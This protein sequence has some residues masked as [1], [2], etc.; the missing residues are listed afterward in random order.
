MRVAAP[1]FSSR[2]H[3]PAFGA[4]RSALPFISS[5]TSCRKLS[6]E[7]NGYQIVFCRGTDVPT[8]LAAGLVDVGLM[9]YDVSVEWC[10]RMHARLDI[11]SLAP[12]RLSFV[13]FVSVRGRTVKR[14]YSEY[15]SITRCWVKKTNA[16]RN[17]EIIKVHG[18]SEGII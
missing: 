18:S 4:L 10:A 17:A 11:L 2:F 1:S 6:V 9:G 12:T 14:I 16:L 8:V 15:E 3:S 5:V 13:S 7:E